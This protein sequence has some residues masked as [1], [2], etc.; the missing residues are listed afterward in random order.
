M[1]KYISILRGI[2]VS[3]QKKIVMSDLKALFTLLGFKNIVTYIQSGNVI[4]ECKSI[5]KDTVKTE[6]EAAIER[7]YSFHVTVQIFTVEQFN[8]ILN[9]CPFKDV[10]IDNDGSK[11]FFSFLSAKPNPAIFEDVAKVAT[12]TEKIISSNQVIY[13]HCPNGYGRSKLSNV[14]LERKLNVSATTRNWKTVSKL[15]ELAQN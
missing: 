1:N 4:F 14:F 5:D 12:N 8:Q 9:D 15:C 6:I 7:Q 10:S 11:V 3:G 2:N 13:L